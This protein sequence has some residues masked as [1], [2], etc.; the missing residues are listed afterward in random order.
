MRRLAH[1]LLVPLTL[2]LAAPLEA[3]ADALDQESAL[4]EGEVG[5]IDVNEFFSRAQTFTVGATGVLTR[6]RLSLGKASTIPGDALRFD[7]RPTTESGAPVAADEA[8]LGLVVVPAEDVPDSP[9]IT[10]N[11][12]IDFRSQQILVTEGE[13]LAIVAR[14]SVPF[15]A[16]RS[17]AIIASVG[18]SYAGGDAWF[19]FPDWSLQ[20]LGGTDWIFETY[21]PEPDGALGA[22]LAAL[23]VLARARTARRGRRHGS[24]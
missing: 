20:D 11:F 8:A 5:S 17:L 3:R 19:G 18:G 2:V 6:V 24:A 22:A 21:V 23:A 15:D 13:V 16:G 12:D 10:P 14:S 1:L 9:G 7:V 4:G